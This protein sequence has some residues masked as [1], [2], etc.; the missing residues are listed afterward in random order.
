MSSSYSSTF[1]GNAASAIA[2]EASDAG[3]GAVEQLHFLARLDH[4]IDQAVVLRLRRGHV[5][6]AIGIRPNL[7][8]GLAGVLR[9]DSDQALLQLEHVFDLRSTSLACP[10][11]RR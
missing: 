6:V 3:D 11:R 10:A 5:V 7:L 9:D 8:L 2:A 1:R 4:F